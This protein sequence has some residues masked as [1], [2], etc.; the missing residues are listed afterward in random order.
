MKNYLLAL[1]LMASI[2][3]IKLLTQPAQLFKT[4]RQLNEQVNYKH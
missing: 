2:V 1:T 4:N 3:P